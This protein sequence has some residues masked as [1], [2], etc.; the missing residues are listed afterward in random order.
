[1]K[2]NKKEKSE[3]AM[4]IMVTEKK[5]KQDYDLKHRT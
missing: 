2:Q 1:M 4:E 5:S 3:M